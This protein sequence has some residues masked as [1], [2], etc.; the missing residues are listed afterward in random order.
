[1]LKNCPEIIPSK[2]IRNGVAAEPLR[3]SIRDELKLPFSSTF[4]EHIEHL[5]PVGAVPGNRIERDF[6]DLL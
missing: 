5:A 2:R 3:N 6:F 1:M 4:A